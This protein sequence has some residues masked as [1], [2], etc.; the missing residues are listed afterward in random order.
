MRAALAAG[1]ASAAHGGGGLGT[2]VPRG[3]SGGGGSGCGGGGDRGDGGGGRRCAGRTSSAVL[4]VGMSEV[5][6]KP[7]KLPTVAVEV[8]VVESDMTPASA[9]TVSS[10]QKVAMT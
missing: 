6:G 9:A 10:P 8:M 3:R 2:G 5:V 1:V 7:T 4:T